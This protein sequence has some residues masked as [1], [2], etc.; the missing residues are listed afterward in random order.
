MKTKLNLSQFEDCYTA[1]QKAFYANELQ[2]ENKK[3]FKKLKK[4]I[5]NTMYKLLSANA[6][7]DEK[8]VRVGLNTLLTLTL[9]NYSRFSKKT[10]E[11]VRPLQQEINEKLGELGD[12][13]RRY[14]KAA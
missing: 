12:S 1:F 7:L 2:S 14:K 5:E 9:E 3:G 13:K 11:Q 6:K 4:A 8:G 10:K